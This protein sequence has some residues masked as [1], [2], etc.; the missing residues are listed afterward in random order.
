MNTIITKKGAQ[1][2]NMSCYFRYR[3]GNFEQPV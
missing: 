3:E 1:A 2:H